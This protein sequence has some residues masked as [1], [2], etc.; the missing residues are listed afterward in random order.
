MFATNLIKPT[1]IVQFSGIFN[2]RFA[3]AVA[4]YLTSTYREVD[5]G[6]PLQG[7]CVPNRTAVF[8]NDF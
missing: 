1:Y 7:R 4:N 5:G 6:E 3:I 2:C 8:E